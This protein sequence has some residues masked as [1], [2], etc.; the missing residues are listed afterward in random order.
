MRKG[1]GRLEGDGGDGLDGCCGDGK[2]R[3]GRERR[4]AGVGVNNERRGEE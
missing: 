3:S 4:S 1:G 2:K